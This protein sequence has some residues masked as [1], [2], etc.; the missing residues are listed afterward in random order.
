MRLIVPA[1]APP[2]IRGMGR[3]WMISVG[4]LCLLL[5][6]CG[7]GRPGPRV[8]LAARVAEAMGPEDALR[9]QRAEIRALDSDRVVTWRGGDAGLWG[10]VRPVRT[11]HGQGRTCREIMHTVV[12]G[13]SARDVRGILC[14]RADGTWEVM[15]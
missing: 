6:G 13:D 11:L 8:F 3:Q 10:G 7:D 1:A 14:R 12:T 9:A 15:D 4:A 5:A 2:H